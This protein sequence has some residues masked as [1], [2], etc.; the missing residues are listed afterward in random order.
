MLET[1]ACAGSSSTSCSPAQALVPRAPKAALFVPDLE[2]GPPLTTYSYHVGVNYEEF[3]DCSGCASSAPAW[4]GQGEGQ[5]GRLRV[6][7]LNHCTAPPNTCNRIIFSKLVASVGIAHFFLHSD[8][9]IQS[10]LLKLA[11]IA[12]YCLLLDL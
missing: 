5:S 7:P 11:M 1:D 10:T 12:S 8:V 4:A 3:L 9:A 2:V 6:R